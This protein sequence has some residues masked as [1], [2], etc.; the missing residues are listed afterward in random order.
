MNRNDI[1][2]NNHSSTDLAKILL[3][4]PGFININ[5][6]K[7]GVFKNK[8]VAKLAVVMITLTVVTPLLISIAFLFK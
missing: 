1:K 6:T 2:R 5:S 4:T 3:R 7:L 8:T